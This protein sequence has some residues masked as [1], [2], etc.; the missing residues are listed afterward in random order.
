[1]SKLLDALRTNDA[2][3]EN[4]MVTNSTSLN[5]CTDA[6]FRLGAMRASSEQ[7]ILSV[8]TAAFNE[9]KLTAMRLLFW[10]R[11]IRG[12]SG[13]RKIFRVILNYL[14]K[15]HKDVVSKNLHLIPEYGRWDDLIALIGTLLEKE[16]LDL[17]SKNFKSKAEADEILSFIDSYSEEECE[18]LLAEIR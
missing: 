6:F 10:V 14:A 2:F 5:K 11:D 16:A 17:I 9:D 7:E 4:G 18:K 12:G 1:M 13:E 3:T 15:N 8:F